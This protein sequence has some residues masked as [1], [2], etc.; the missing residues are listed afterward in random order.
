MENLD[1]VK[2]KI[3]E[4]MKKHNYFLQFFLYL[5]ALDLYLSKTDPD[6]SYEKSFGEVVYIFLRGVSDKPE[7]E[8]GLYRYRPKLATV[9]AVQRLFANSRKDK[10]G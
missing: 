2:E 5:A 4:E 8:T 1:S 3:K 10:N 6:Y 7:S 9:K